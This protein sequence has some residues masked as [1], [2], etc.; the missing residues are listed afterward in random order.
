MK[1]RLKKEH[2]RYAAAQKLG[3]KFGGS[4]SVNEELKRDLESIKYQ[5]R[6]AGNDDGYIVKFLGMCETHIVGPDGFSFQSL[7]T[8]KAGKFDKKAQIVIENEWKRWTKLGHCDVT[9]QYSWQD[10]ENL[11]IRTVAEDG[12]ILLRLVNGFENEH[13]FAVQIIDC[14]HLD[15]NYNQENYNG[16]RIR[17][18]VEIDS[19]NR[20]LAYH[21]LTT[22][23]SE[24]S[25]FHC[26]RRYERITK[27]EIVLKFLPRRIGQLRGL[28]W[29]HAALLEMHHLHGYR[30]AELT[31]ARIAASKMLAYKPDSDVE[32]DGDDDTEFIEEVEPG[33]SVVVPYGYDIDVLDWKTSGTNF[34]DFNKSGLRGA[35]SGLDVGYN[36]LANDL[37]G[38]N[39]SSL[40]T[41][42]LEDRDGWMKRQRWM[43]QHL[44]EVVFSSWLKMSLLMGRLGNLGLLDIKRLSA[45]KF[46]GRR[47]QWVDP[48]KDEKANSEAIKN[49]TKSELQ[50]IRERGDDPETVISEILQFE[51]MIGDLRLRRA[52]A[53]TETHVKNKE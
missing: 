27:D 1:E 9:E 20:P 5:S 4:L 42:V 2:V 12:E 19:W 15:I 32:P 39:F 41:S 13:G 33:M 43:K 48:L 28:P 23:P 46:Q 29:A 31:S 26:N 36:I 21:V 49:C 6:Q 17:M 8:T 30:E 11:F 22:H 47:W 52:Q 40:R 14:A 16:N 18:S 45:C 38:V 50:I 3:R 25:Y 7:A 24:Q 44:H 37:E 10:I 35:A 34:G 51:E 53:K